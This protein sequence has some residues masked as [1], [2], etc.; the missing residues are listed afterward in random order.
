MSNVKRPLSPSLAVRPPRPIKCTTL[1]TRK[2][3]HHKW[4]YLYSIIGPDASPIYVGQTVNEKKRAAAH[5]GEASKCKLLR[6]CILQYRHEFP[7]WRFADNFKR[8]PALAHGAPFGDVLDMY[9]CYFIQNIV[10]SGVVSH[11]KH[12]PYACNQ[13]NGPNYSEHRSKFVEIR[14][15]LSALE[16]GECLY[17]AQDE[18]DAK[19]ASVLITPISI[20]KAEHDLLERMMK[21]TCANDGTPLPEIDECFQLAVTKLAVLTNVQETAC[22]VN[23]LLKTADAK[24][25]A[26]EHIDAAWLAKEFNHLKTMLGDY[27]A[28]DSTQALAHTFLSRTLHM[29]TVDICNGE[30]WAASSLDA[31][32]VHCMATALQMQLRHRESYCAVPARSFQSICAWLK[33]DTELKGGETDEK[34]LERATE[35]LRTHH[36]SDEQRAEVQRFVQQLEARI[37]GAEETPSAP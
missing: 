7:N 15:A 10:S 9:E 16:P 6:E 3:S 34:K 32:R 35:H 33:P 12:N 11:H 21:D 18:R 31:N 17:T 4:G 22:G 24:R 23:R 36:F 2:S 25:K 13:N 30:E 26:Y 8:I 20:A 1:A 29:C 19:D 27:V 28:S 37:K 14:E 5:E